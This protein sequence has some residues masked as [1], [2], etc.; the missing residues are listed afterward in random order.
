ME[1]LSLHEAVP[2]HHLQIALAQEIEH[3]PELRRQLGYNAFVEGWALYAE[4]L[5]G[6]MG[7]Y[8]DPYSRF[9]A[10]TYQMW[11]AIRLV[12][13]TGIHSMGWTRE[14]AI[15]Y[16]KDNSTKPE[17]D[18]TVEVDRYIAWPGQAL[19]YMLGAL[20]IRALRDSAQR[21]LGDRFDIRAFH[22]AVLGQGSMPLDLLEHRIGEWVETQRAR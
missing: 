1:A 10:A 14:Q 3:V 22:D 13:D 17:H 2:G 9:G 4:T 15:A 20:R 21:E 6:Q 11:R 5:G 18:I 16:F 12:L 8:T 19:G 7:F